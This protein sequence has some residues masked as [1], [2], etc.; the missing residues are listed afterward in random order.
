[1]VRTKESST[2]TRWIDRIGK[3]NHRQGCLGLGLL[4]D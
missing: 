1:L 4:L 2:D 3:V